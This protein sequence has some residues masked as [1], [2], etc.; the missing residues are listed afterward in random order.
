MQFGRLL[1]VPLTHSAFLRSISAIFA[2]EIRDVVF[3]D[4]DAVDV[5]HADEP[6][7]LRIANVDVLAIDNLDL[8]DRRDANDFDFVAVFQIG[9]TVDAVKQV[10]VKDVVAI[11]ASHFRHI[12]GS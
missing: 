11:E 10:R 9:A 6:S 8:S 5:H 1:V 3:L 4:V 12:I 7:G 2:L